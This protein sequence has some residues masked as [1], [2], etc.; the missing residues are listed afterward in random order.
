MAEALSQDNSIEK[1]INNTENSLKNITLVNFLII[2][3]L[4]IVVA[5][6]VNEVLH[7][8]ALYY[9]ETL[10]RKE[11]IQKFLSS[12]VS[13]K[14]EVGHLVKCFHVSKS[15]DTKT[16]SG[17]KVVTYSTVENFDYQTWKDFSDLRLIEPSPDYPVIE[18]EI[19]LNFFPGDQATAEKYKQ[20]VQKLTKAHSGKDT[21][22]SIDDYFHIEDQK[23]WTFYIGNKKF[24]SPWWEKTPARLLLSCIFLFG[25]LFRFSYKGKVAK[26]RIE[27]KKAVFVE[28]NCQ[29]E[30]VSLTA[31]PGSSLEGCNTSVKAVEPES[32]PPYLEPAPPVEAVRVC[33]SSASPPSLKDATPL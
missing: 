5:A 11:D 3:I 8:K 25:W 27:V 19:V 32:P 17:H 13:K 14:P 29:D 6:N 1:C 2:F 12:L 21:K 4:I 22:I 10:C 9:Q 18:V 33:S 15:A 24:I 26:H 7:A 28:S 20:F 23:E 16:N 31:T 30:G